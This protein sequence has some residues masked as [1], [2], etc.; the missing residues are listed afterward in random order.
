MVRTDGAWTRRGHGAGLAALGLVM[1]A[2]LAGCGGGPSGAGQPA[3]AGADPVGHI[4]YCSLLTAQEV[5]TFLGEQVPP[6]AGRTGCRWKTGEEFGAR[7][8]SDSVLEVRRGDGWETY[9]NEGFTPLDGVGD[10]ALQFG[11]QQQYTIVARIA[12]G[13]FRV[14]SINLDPEKT[15]TAARLALGRI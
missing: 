5:A 13:G 14:D 11:D 6:E 10:R 2:V 7:G 9:I 8:G 4:D 12:A 15:R 3:A 1:A